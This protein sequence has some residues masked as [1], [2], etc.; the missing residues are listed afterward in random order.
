[1]WDY[2]KK[3][4][5]QESTARRFQ[6]EYEMANFTQR[7]L[8]IEE[9]FSGFQNLWVEYSNIIYVGISDEALSTI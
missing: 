6:L 3:F 4:Y 7:S 5:N 1:M 8:S 2:L 9:Y